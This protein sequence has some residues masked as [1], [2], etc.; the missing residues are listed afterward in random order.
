MDYDSGAVFAPDF[1]CGAEEEG[2]GESETHD[3]DKDDVSCAAYRS[4]C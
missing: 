1:G 2:D 4:G 3:N